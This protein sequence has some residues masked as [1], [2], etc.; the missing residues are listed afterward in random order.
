ME[1]VMKTQLGDYIKEGEKPLVYKENSHF[2]RKVSGWLQYTLDK[3]INTDVFRLVEGFEICGEP[4]VI[5]EFINKKTHKKV[6]EYILDLLG[7]DF[8]GVRQM[9]KSGNHPFRNIFCGNNSVIFTDVKI[10]DEV[11]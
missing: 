10:D 6:K 7:L 11:K 8:V 1:I 9:D 2:S 5:M 3:N 4:C